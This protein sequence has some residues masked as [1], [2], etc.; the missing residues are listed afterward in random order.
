LTPPVL[1]EGDWLQC[2]VTREDKLKFRYTTTS[3]TTTNTTTTAASRFVP[4]HT[5]PRTRQLALSTTQ[6]IRTLVTTCNDTHAP[7]ARRP[8]P[9]TP[10]FP[11]AYPTRFYV[12]IG[13][14]EGRFVLS[15]VQYGQTFYIS[16]YES[17]PSDFDP[18][19]LD[20]DAPDQKFC[21][22]LKK[23]ESKDTCEHELF[24]LREDTPM[25]RVRHS[26]AHFE[27]P[28]TDIRTLEVAM[29]GEAVDAGTP[30]SPKFNWDIAHPLSSPKSLGRHRSISSGSHG[31]LRT[32]EGEL[33]LKNQLP[34]WNPE[35]ECLVMKFW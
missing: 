23:V 17:F 18:T 13:E 25:V 21:A 28:G 32:E 9:P 35:S 20:M 33:L 11:P 19:D 22:V 16:Q 14:N 27:E 24:A 12:E 1:D 10:P 2:V 15:A 31:G 6:P 34:S 29:R 4:F 26:S 5:W 3:T 7:R 8:R 30:A